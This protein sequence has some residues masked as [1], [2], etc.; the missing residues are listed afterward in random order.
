MNKT[1]DS[2]RK[3]SAARFS[4]LSNTFLTISK[5][6]AGLF[7]GSVSIISEGIHS[8]MDLI[9]SL[10]AYF[11]VKKSALPP[12]EDHAFGH[13][14]YEDASGL[15]E[16]LLIVLAAGIIIWEAVS[17]LVRGGETVSV[18]LLYVGL[19]VMG[20]SALMN[21]FVSQYLLKV[22]KETD[23]I[24]LESDGWHLRT[25]VLTS[26]GVFLGLLIIQITGFVWIDS[27]I[28]IVVALFILKEAYS[29]I[30]RSFTDLM[31]GSLEAEEIA[32]IEEIICRHADEY[33]NF[34]GLKTRK[35]GPDKFAVFHLM[36][37]AETPLAEAH[38]LV[39]HI[40][41]EIQEEIPRIYLTVHLDPCDK[42][43]GVD[44][45][46]FVCKGK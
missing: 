3:K 19:I 5:I 46:E 33:T 22:A 8:G 40:E 14:K 26:G 4:I 38:D 6:L 43:C 2:T 37:P 32:K 10:I 17:K 24:A 16:A 15:V 7:T 44:E 31:D 23:S 9:A 20:V 45:C 35:A 34:H 12:D 28:A 13:G 1:N 18:D 42:R 36:M 29:L 11:S 41:E 21:F 30:R 25:D 39:K 27:V